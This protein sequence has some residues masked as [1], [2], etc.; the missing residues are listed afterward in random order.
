M[1][2]DTLKGEFENAKAKMKLISCYCNNGGY[3]ID[4]NQER[5]PICFSENKQE[6][7]CENII[8][9]GYFITKN[10]EPLNDSP[11]PEGELKFFKVISY[12]CQ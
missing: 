11:C 1:F 5:I 9:L 6:I 4:E 7:K 3:V 8:V 2:L 12:K 10:I